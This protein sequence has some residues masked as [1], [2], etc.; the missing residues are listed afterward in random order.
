[1]RTFTRCHGLAL[2][3]ML[4]VVVPEVGAHHRSNLNNAN[5]RAATRQ[6]IQQMR[7]AQQAALA[8]RAAS[9]NSSRRTNSFSIFNPF[10]TAQAVLST[11]RT[12]PGGISPFGNRALTG[13]IPGAA[14]TATGTNLGAALTA[15]GTLPL[16]SGFGTFADPYGSYGAN[17]YGSYGE[18]QLGGY[19]RGYADVIGS[20]GRLEVDEQRAN[21]Q[22]QQVQRERLENWKRHFDY[23]RYWRE[24]VPTAEDD[25]QRYLQ[26]QLTRSLNDPPPG[27][28]YS[29]QAMNTL[30]DNL[31]KKV[32]SGTDLPGGS[33]ALDADT[34]RHLNVTATPGK[35]NPGLLKN[36]GRLSWPTALR[37]P[38]FEPERDVISNLAPVLYD[39]AV[40]GRVD[41]VSLANM[42]NALRELDRK[43]T[44]SVQDMSPNQYAETRRFLSALGGMATVLGQPG[45]G[46]HLSPAPKG[47]TIGDLV[48]YMLS[49]GLRF[50]P[51]VSG[52]EGAYQAAY[53]AL[54]HFYDALSTKVVA[55]KPEK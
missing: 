2:V 47:R 43:L 3:A 6:A 30:L 31:A 29:G 27:E 46:D 15:T 1:M 40:R 39:Q 21:L 8:G 11:P 38:L 36:E 32:G 20:I 10:S 41:P 4:V 23:W 22:R 18:S 19:L 42:N 7:A 34:L 48:Q 37:E 24:N 45:A 55:E 50:A 14:L 17:P 35:G 33:P 49:K 9:L 25:R 28:V 5:F 16:N 26:A 44:E 54:V 52:D 51:A 13:A 53:A 12:F